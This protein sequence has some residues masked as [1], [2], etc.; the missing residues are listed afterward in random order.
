MAGLFN[1]EKQQ[2]MLAV[3]IRLELEKRHW[4]VHQLAKQA[5]LPLRAVQRICA[6]EGKQPSIW[7]LAYIALTLNI[8]VDYLIG[9]TGEQADSEV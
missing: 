8:S 9:L 5:Q 6:G 2:A 3:R 7:T 4:G 1:I